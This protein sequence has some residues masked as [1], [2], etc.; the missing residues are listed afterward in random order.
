[1]RTI[2]RDCVVGMIWSKDG[3][4]LLGKKD[5]NGG[6]VYPDSWH[7]PGGGIEP[8]ESHHDALRREIKEEIGIDILPFQVGFVDA[9]GTGQAEK[10]DKETGETVL[11]QMHFY[12]YSVQIPYPATS[13]PVRP[14]SD[15]KE[16]VWVSKSDF[17]NYW[18]NPPSMALFTRLGYL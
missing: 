7:L 13:I 16:L 3:K 14:L 9:S 18:L 5:P 15:L 12:V 10:T 2:Q 4:L 8:D 11:C 17:T 6:G 1:M